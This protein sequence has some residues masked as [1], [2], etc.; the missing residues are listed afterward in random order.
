MTPA[1]IIA[2]AR[3]ISWTDS[4][5]FTDANALI[6]LN[7]IKDEFWSAIL[8]SVPLENYNWQRWTVENTVAGQSEYT[9]PTIAY[10]TAG[11]KIVTGIG[12][13]YNG[14]VY[15]WTTTL[16]YLK[17]REVAMD[18]LQYDWE[19]YVNTQSEDDPI[20]C[21]A[22]N[23]IFIAPAPKT[24]VTGGFKVQGI[25]KIPDYTL[26]TTEAEMMIPV[27]QQRAM[28]YGLAVFG[29]FNKK[30]DENIIASAEAR[31]ERKKQEAIKSMESRDIGTTKFEYPSDE[32]DEIIL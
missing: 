2:Q 13:N 25:R 1:Q 27:D 28:I 9:I 17:P 8:T 16:K 6:A 26:S 32:S 4:S 19:Y 21:V 29:L 23:S 20:Y 15:P 24:N 7:T 22:D 5:Q 31:W 11:T 10:N 18:G 30:A 3:I 12:I 14:E